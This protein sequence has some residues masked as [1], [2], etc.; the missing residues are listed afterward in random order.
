[1]SKSF[2]VTVNAV[3]DA[4]VFAATQ[5]ALSLTQNAAMTNVVAPLATDVDTPTLTYAMTGLPTGVSFD[6]ATRTVSG[7]PTATGT[8]TVTYTATD[9]TSTVTQSFQAIV[10]A[11][12]VPPTMGDVPNQTGSTGTAFSLNLSSYVTPTNGDAILGYAV[13]SGS[14]PPGVTLN[15]AT[16]AIAGIPTTA[17]TYSITVLAYDTDGNSNA[18]SVAFSIADAVAPNAP[19][20]TSGYA[21]VTSAN[22]VT[23]EV[24]GEIGS[25]V[26]VNGSSTGV[27]IG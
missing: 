13:A 2:S 9:G 18:D 4:P 15:T 27:T 17:G 24:N 6:P 19:T 10:S 3:N 23:V 16:G 8:Y 1:M 5:S 21:T 11:A 25:T 26:W 22:S 7:T 12:H 20:V 14:L